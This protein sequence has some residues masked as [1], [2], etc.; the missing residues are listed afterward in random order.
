MDLNVS[1]VSH[2][3]A[4][5]APKEAE[6]MERHTHTLIPD[7]V[8]AGTRAT[9]LPGKDRAPRPARGCSIPL[10]TQGLPRAGG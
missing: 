1:D 8:A 5:A 3:V 2:S 7:Q 10:V 9:G 6:W 4:L